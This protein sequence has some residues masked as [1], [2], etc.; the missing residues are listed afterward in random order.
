MRKAYKVLYC[1]NVRD[2]VRYE[3]WQYLTCLI[4]DSAQL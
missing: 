4:T 1:I 3:Q 2:Y